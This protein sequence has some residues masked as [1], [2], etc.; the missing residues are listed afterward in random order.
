[1]SFLSELKKAI[2]GDLKP[3]PVPYQEIEIIPQSEKPIDWELTYHQMEGT[4]ESY[5]EQDRSDDYDANLQEAIQREHDL[6]VKL[7][8][9]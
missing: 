7:E 2:I 4:A 5:L 8:N 3:T 1:M 9:R 6:M